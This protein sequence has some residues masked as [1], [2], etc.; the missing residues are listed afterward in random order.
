MNNVPSDWRRCGTIRLYKDTN[1]RGSTMGTLTTNNFD[2]HSNTTDSQSEQ[3]SE[4]GYTMQTDGQWFAFHST[5][6]DSKL[7]SKKS[8]SFRYD[9]QGATG[10][11]CYVDFY[12]KEF[13]ESTKKKLNWQAPTDSKTQNLTSLYWEGGDGDIHDDLQNVVMKDYSYGQC[14]KDQKKTFEAGHAFKKSLWTPDG[15]NG[16]KEAC[17]SNTNVNE[18]LQKCKDLGIDI[19]N[20][21]NYTDVTKSETPHNGGNCYL[22][23]VDQIDKHCNENHAEYTGIGGYKAQNIKSPTIRDDGTIDY[24]G[25]EGEPACDSLYGI[26]K[27]WSDMVETRKLGNLNL[28]G[29]SQFPQNLSGLLLLRKACENAEIGW[30]ECTETKLTSLDNEKMRQVLEDTLQTN[31]IAT[32]ILEQQAAEMQAG[33]LALQQSNIQAQQA[34]EIAARFAGLNPTNP[35]DDD[36]KDTMLYIA[37]G[38]IA[39]TLCCCCILILVFMTKKST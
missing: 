13:A 32:G 20:L 30:D 10:G 38:G 17:K 1:L 15:I 28:D 27:V 16:T 21:T 11:H 2:S 29:G 14:I 12:N 4:R 39:L 37:G 5:I 23:D 6:G 9:P 19:S 31:V 33:T 18:T 36:D 24:D 26:T 34:N 22:A 25:L 35:K 7:E 3:T 8:S